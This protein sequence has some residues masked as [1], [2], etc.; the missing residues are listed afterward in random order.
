MRSDRCRQYH[1]LMDDMRVTSYEC[2]IRN[3]VKGKVKERI[4]V[5]GLPSHSYGTSLAIW[6]H[7]VLPA[8]SDTS[9]RAP[10]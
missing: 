2:S 9:E 5:N 8:I 7:T 6:D 4:T 3:H 10:P 1:R